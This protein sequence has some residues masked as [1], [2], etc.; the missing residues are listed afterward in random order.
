[1]AAIEAA[2]T[3]GLEL[4]ESSRASS[5]YLNVE[6]KHAKAGEFFELARYVR[7]GPALRYATAEEAALAYVRQRECTASREGG[8]EDGAEAAATGGDGGEAA[9][10]GG[11]GGG[12]APRQQRR[13]AVLSQA[14]VSAWAA[15]E[16]EDEP[17]TMGA[18][19]SSNA[20]GSRKRRRPSTSS[21]SPVPREAEP[22]GGDAE[23]VC[24]FMA[25]LASDDELES[26]VELV[27]RRF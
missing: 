23:P 12:A 7:V 19:S 5:G 4:K 21:A 2:Q 17:A 15:S 10:A 1:M 24:V 11:D 13:S 3:E 8:C 16:A 18:A 25:V 27:A 26:S 6:R 14:A 20:N 22:P 9:A